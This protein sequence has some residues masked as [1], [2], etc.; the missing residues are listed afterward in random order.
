MY[1]SIGIV[2]IPLFSSYIHSFIHTEY[3]IISIIIEWSADFNLFDYICCLL[4]YLFI[5]YNMITCDM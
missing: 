2:I 4:V 1:C 5:L 3:I